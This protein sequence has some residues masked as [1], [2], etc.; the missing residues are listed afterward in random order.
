MAAVS[1]PFLDALVPEA[2]DEVPGTGQDG[3]AVSEPFYVR[4]TGA[5]QGTFAGDATVKG[6][7]GWL[8]GVA[9]DQTATAP[10]DP[11]SANPTG[12]VRTAPVEI[13][14]HWS[15]A[16]PQLLTALYENERLSSVV[17]EF[18][19]GT[20]VH[21][22]LTLTDAVLTG[23]RRLGGDRPPV[24]TVSLQA[25]RLVLE[26]VAERKSGSVQTPWDVHELGEAPAAATPA[27]PGPWRTDLFDIARAGLS[28]C[29][30]TMVA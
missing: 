3:R 30:T 14:L 28:P 15:A 25:A 29:R 6:R 11:A 10:R 21:Q 17:C 2:E 5:T 23:L 19:R 18:T 24:E 22:R 7:S 9:F 20:E 12:R 13:T 1:T 27:P 8:E 16:S 26:D 4:I